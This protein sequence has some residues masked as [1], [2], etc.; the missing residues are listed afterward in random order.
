MEFQV[1]G[2]YG[3][4]PTAAAGTSGYLLRS[5]DTNILLD[6]GSGVLRELEKVMDPLQLDAVVL[7]H[8]HHD[9]TADVG[10]LQYL[11]QLKQG[12]KKEPIL[13]IYGNTQNPIEFATLTWPGAT[14]GRAYTDTAPVTI[15]PLTFTFQRTIH[16]VPAFA[17]RITE[18][19]TGKVLAFTA[20][21]RYYPELADFVQ[22]AD[23]LITDTN[24]LNDYQGVAWHMTAGQSGQL[25]QDAGVKQLIISHLPQEA[26][27]TKLQE[28]A[29]AA[30]GSIKVTLASNIHGLELV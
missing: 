17:M 15:G 24:F 12:P 8:Y 29:Q 10:V 11:W 6:A 23:V 1:L 2:Y 19:G 22:G 20:D 30:A 7:S 5:G 14:V 3:G 26:S 21:T 16:P 18:A 4:Y 28:Q 25:A 9:H 27:L 13:P